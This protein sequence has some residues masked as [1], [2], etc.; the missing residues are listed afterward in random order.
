MDT[1]DPDITF[2]VD[3]YC[4]HCTDAIE[5]LNEIYFIDEEFRK[6]RLETIVDK[7]KKDGKGKKYDCIIGLS[8]GVDSSYL[9]YVAVKELKLRPLAV[10]VDNGWN[11]ELAVNNIDNIV[12]MLGIDLIT[13]VLDWAEFREIQ[14]AFFRSS[15]IDLELTSDYAIYASIQKVAH[16]NRIKYFLIGSNIA[17][18]SIMPKK[19]FY[20]S[21]LDFLN[22][23]NIVS[24]N[25]KLKITTFPSISLIDF[26]IYNKFGVK[27]MPILNFINYD[28]DKAKSTIMTE[29]NWKDY[30]GKHQESRITAF[31]QKY[32]LPEKFNVDKRKAH[33]SSLICSNQISR[34]KA[35]EYL[36][37]EVYNSDNLLE[38]DIEYFCKKI[39]ISRSYFERIM[40]EE[41]VEHSKYKSYQELK[42]KLYNLIMKMSYGKIKS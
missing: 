29:V 11:S 38:E 20:S 12:N 2:D 31:Y 23:K 8:G 21:K 16:K 1:T 7:I 36:T 9:A 42:E 3:G 35:L 39:R 14:L 10:H 34:E 15:V 27:N 24:K 28:K 37:K 33:L 40:K 26:L 25:S 5:R 22:I 4:N 30:G 18:E 6:S 32:I 41:R 17:T 19:W 13:V